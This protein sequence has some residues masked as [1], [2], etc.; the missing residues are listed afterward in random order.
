M[1]LPK[2][3]LLYIDSIIYIHL[4]PI[5]IYSSHILN[6]DL[7]FHPVFHPFSSLRNSDKG[8]VRCVVSQNLADIAWTPINSIQA[9]AKNETVDHH[10]EERDVF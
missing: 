5:G 6:H 7:Q 1:Y 4:P 9:E 2:H 3:Y 8:H 10:Q